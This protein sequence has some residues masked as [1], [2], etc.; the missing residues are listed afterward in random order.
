MIRFDEIF[1]LP[2]MICL[3]DMLKD[4]IKFYMICDEILFDNLP[5]RICDLI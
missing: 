2:D 1:K 3:C 4:V 5:H